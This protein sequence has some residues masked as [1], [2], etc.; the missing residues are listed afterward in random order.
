MFK[1]TDKRL[2]DS[3]IVGQ[4]DMTFVTRFGAA[5]VGGV[6]AAAVGV[7]A[8]LGTFVGVVGR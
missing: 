3:S 8:V 4:S 1:V 5:A 2:G 7:F 6:A